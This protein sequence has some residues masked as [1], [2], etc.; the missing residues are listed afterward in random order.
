M[1]AQDFVAIGGS[2]RAYRADGRAIPGD[3]EY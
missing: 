1:L 2:D 3:Y